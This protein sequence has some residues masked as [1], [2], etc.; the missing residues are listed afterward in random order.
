VINGTWWSPQLFVLSSHGQ[1]GIS[2]FCN[3]YVEYLPTISTGR[4]F[5]DHCCGQV[6]VEYEDGTT[7]VDGGREA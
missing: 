6:L 1:D 5:W 4:E 2:R 3:A 7:A